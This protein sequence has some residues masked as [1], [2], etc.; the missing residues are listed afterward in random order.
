M[1]RMKH[2]LNTIY[3]FAELMF[4]ATPIRVLHMFFSVMMGSI[5]A[6]FNAIYFLSDGTILEGRHYAY[7]VLD[8]KNPAEAIV[9]CVL[10]IIQAAFSQ[11]VIY[12]WFKL[13][14]WIF[15][16]VYFSPECS[17]LTSPQDGSEMQSIMT[18]SPKYMTLDNKNLNNIEDNGHTR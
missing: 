9:T 8:W 7:N 15:G 11:I 3:V 10:C 2:T 18:N 5:Y 16:R 14:S 12:E 13:R 1:S 17:E 4:S 6:M